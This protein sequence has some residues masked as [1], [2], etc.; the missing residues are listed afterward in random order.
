MR[1]LV[2][3]AAVSAALAVWAA[4]A[5]AATKREIDDAASGLSGA[6]AL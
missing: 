3:V 4:P 5:G 1:S 6:P 2:V